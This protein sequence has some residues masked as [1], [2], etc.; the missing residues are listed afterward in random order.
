[1]PNIYQNELQEPEIYDVRKVEL[2]I[3][4]QQIT[5]IGEDGFGIT[6]SQETTLIKG[7]KG[8]GG[9]SMDPTSAAE[10]T[11]SLLST[12]PSNEYLRKI[13]AQQSPPG[14]ADAPVPFLFEAKV[15]AGYEAA[16][17][18]SFKKIQYCMIVGPPEL[19]TEKEAPQYEWKFVGYGYDEGPVGA[20][21]WTRNA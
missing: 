11:V 9:F 18:Y 1:M 21:E 17:G 12:S 4:G 10:A 15:K 6:P 2:W 20:L 7:L 19:V 5:G 3:N 8:E 13:L 16:F 14:N